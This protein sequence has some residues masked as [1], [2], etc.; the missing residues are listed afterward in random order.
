MNTVVVL[1]AVVLATA[2]GAKRQYSE[3]GNHIITKD[4]PAP[5]SP[6]QKSETNSDTTHT[7]SAPK[8]GAQ[9]S[10]TGPKGS[11]SSSSKTT[12]TPSSATSSDDGEEPMRFVAGVLIATVIFLL[13]LVSGVLIV[14]FVPVLFDSLFCTHEE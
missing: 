6:T 8:P 4:P 9:P 7:T 5:A 2:T 10:S 12:Q 3:D 13:V 1:I 11:S 14:C